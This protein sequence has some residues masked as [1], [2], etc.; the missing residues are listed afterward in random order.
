M[1]EQWVVDQ[2]EQ[3]LQDYFQ[4]E[5]LTAGLIKQLVAVLAPD[6]E[7]IAVKAAYRDERTSETIF[8]G[9]ADFND[10]DDI[11]AVMVEELTEN[12]RAVGIRTEAGAEIS[13]VVV[14]APF[15]RVTHSRGPAPKLPWEG[16]WMPDRP[17]PSIQN[18]QREESVE[19]KEGQNM[20]KET[21]KSLAYQVADGT[22]EAAE[23]NHRMKAVVTRYKEAKTIEEKRERY[24]DSGGPEIDPNSFIHVEAIKHIGM[25]SKEQYEGIRKGMG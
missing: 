25:I 4:H 7:S 19:R 23:A 2:V 13:P 3:Q 14:A 5:P 22:L 17:I 1:T 15:P 8:E 6:G 24:N 9:N 12:A 21:V 10:L 11:V 16:Q 18:L 20:A